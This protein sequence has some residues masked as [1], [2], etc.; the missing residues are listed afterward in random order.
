[1]KSFTK[2]LSIALIAALISVVIYDQYFNNLYDIP[3]NN[4]NN[5]KNTVLIPTN[6]KVHTNSIADVNDVL[7]EYRDLLPDEY[8]TL[9]GTLNYVI[10]L[11]AK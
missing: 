3:N 9:D 2:S 7:I 5:L 11:L 8:L 10:A 4:N 1:M 6:Y